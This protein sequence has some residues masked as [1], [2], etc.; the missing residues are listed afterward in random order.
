MTKSQYTLVKRSN[1]LALFYGTWNPKGFWN[2]KGVLWLSSGEPFEDPSWVP[3][4]MHSVAS[5]LHYMESKRVLELK[6]VP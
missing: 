5:V 6:K 2:P 1:T 4:K 3:G